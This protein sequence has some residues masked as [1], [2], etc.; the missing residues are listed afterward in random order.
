KLFPITERVNAMFTFDAFNVFNHRYFTSV[1]TREYIE[2]VV[3]GVPVLNPASGFGQGTA[4][5]GFPDGTNARRLQIGA[6][7]VW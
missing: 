1:S 7:I 5:G 3:A 6:R 2:S 4:T